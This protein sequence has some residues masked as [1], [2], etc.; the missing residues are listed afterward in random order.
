VKSSKKIFVA[1]LLTVAVSSVHAAETVI[2]FEDQNVISFNNAVDNLTIDNVTFETLAGGGF[3]IQ[4][5]AN[6]VQ[7]S[8]DDYIGKMLANGGIGFS[9]LKLSFNTSVSDFSFNFGGNQDEWQLNAFNA[10]GLEVDSLLIDS[11]PI[12]G[13]QNGQLFGLS[14]TLPEGISYATLTSLAAPNFLVD[15]VGIDNVKYNTIGNNSSTPP[16]AVSPIPEPS[17]YALML[18]GLGLVGFM[19]YRRRKA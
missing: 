15:T 2:D 1:G 8:S 6:Q 9:S 10:S 5:G 3:V 13:T 7:V 11:I 18:G 4:E 16:P 17:T 12:A 14:S 19:A